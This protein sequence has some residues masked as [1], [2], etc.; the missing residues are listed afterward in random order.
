MDRVFVRQGVTM[1]KPVFDRIIDDFVS[2]LRESKR[3]RDGA[4]DELEELLRR[5]ELRPEQIK[6]VIFEPEDIQ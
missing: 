4:Y 2:R 1:D 5:R 6:R 3:L